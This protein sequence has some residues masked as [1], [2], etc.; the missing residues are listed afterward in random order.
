MKAVKCSIILTI[1]IIL[2]H[3]IQLTDDED[4]Y[5]K[6]DDAAKPKDY[7]IEAETVNRYRSK[8]KNKDALR[9]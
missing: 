1:L 2:A 9:E 8:M 3:S 4:K 5:G 6:P 7:S